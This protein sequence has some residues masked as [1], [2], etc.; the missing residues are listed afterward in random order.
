M[1]R[2]RVAGALRQSGPGRLSPKFRR[3]T[4]CQC[5]KEEDGVILVFWAV[6]LVALVG[7][8]ALVLN[9]GNL[10]QSSDNVQNAADSAAVFGAN[11]TSRAMTFNEIDMDSTF[12][13]T[14]YASGYNV[15]VS[16]DGNTWTDVAACTGTASPEMVA[17]PVQTATYIRVV[18]ALTAT[19]TVPWDIGEFK[20][21][22]D[23]SASP[24][25]SGN[26][27]APLTATAT[28]TQLNEMG[29]VASTNAPTT[30][31]DAPQNAIT[32]AIYGTGTSSANS[33]RFSTDEPQATGLFYQVMNSLFVTTVQIPHAYSCD[34]RLNRCTG[35]P[36]PYAW[37]DGYYIYGSQGLGEGWL[38]I[39]S[40]PPFGGPLPPGEIRD[41]TA[42]R[43]AGA[44]GPGPWRCSV[45]SGTTCTAFKTRVVGTANDA[46]S[47]GA[48]VQATNAAEALVA[49]Y[50]ISAYWTR[51]AAPVSGF[52]L[53]EGWAGVTCIAYCVPAPGVSCGGSD[54]ATF[55]VMALVR[56]PPSLIRADGISCTG[57]SAWGNPSGLAPGA[58][59]PTGTCPPPS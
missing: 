15:E 7:F 56:A 8:L 53:A 12:W 28:T 59:A 6:S 27:S 48:F 25:A 24:P 41:R 35:G 52:Y 51:C 40:G 30:T 37:L 29:L 18:L 23:S 33:T 49:N 16:D 44:R 20:L 36:D 38:Q 10:L 17:F 54:H 19:A 43:Q 45:R 1:R 21:Y 2:S 57:R 47:T 50:G 32:N 42:F 22:Y 13:P 34:S 9:I 31:A 4:L 11:A 46:L 14:N 3:H 26:C 5:S 58:P 39:V 55:L